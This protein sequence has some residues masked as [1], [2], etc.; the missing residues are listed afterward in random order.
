M[1]LKPPVDPGGRT[2]QKRR[3]QFDCRLG[4]LRS[5]ELKVRRGEQGCGV[6][7]AAEGLV[8]KSPQIFVCLLLVSAALC[9]CVPV[10]QETECRKKKK[11]RRR[12]ESVDG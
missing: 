8:L 1:A 11:F 3:Q 2:V 4:S 7:D 10:K 12:G 5:S 6:R 9:S